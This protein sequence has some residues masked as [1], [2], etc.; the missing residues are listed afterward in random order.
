MILLECVPG[1]TC[2]D[3]PARRRLPEPLCLLF[4]HRDMDGRGRSRAGLSY[5]LRGC[6]RHRSHDL[7]CRPE[8]SYSAKAVPSGTSLASV[9][10]AA[11]ERFE[12]V[13]PLSRCRCDARLLPLEILNQRPDRC[14]FCR[15]HIA[16][17]EDRQQLIG[18]RWLWRN[19][20]IA[21]TGGGG[22]IVG[23]GLEA[24]T[25]AALGDR[26]RPA[27][28]ADLGFLFFVINPL[29]SICASRAAF[30]KKVLDFR[31]TASAPPKALRNASLNWPGDALAKPISN[32]AG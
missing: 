22:V 2:T 3:K 29:I 28:A 10:V 27:A 5:P 21:G 8:A 4:H 25:F 12:S 7:P 9:T 17:V 15:F 24:I 31:W 13:P 6:E 26:R 14:L 23:S 20:A 16:H 19:S 1:R 32:I 30:R 18:G 11:A